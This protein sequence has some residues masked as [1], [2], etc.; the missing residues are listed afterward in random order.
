ME[1]PL[2]IDIVVIFGLSIGV[3][4]VGHRLRIP[5]IVGFLLTG[6]IAGPHSLGLVKAVHEVEMM[7]EIGVILLLFTIGIEFSLDKLLQIKRI[8]LVGGLVQVALTVLAS[9][10]VVRSFGQPL[11]HSVFVGFL[12][13]VSSTAI[14]LRLFQ[15]RAEIDSPHGR[16]AL[17]ILIFQDIIVVP[18]MLFTPFLAGQTTNLALELLVLLLKGA[19]IIAF[20]IVGSRWLVPPLLYQ[21]LRTRNRELFLLSI[22][23]LCFAVVLL[24]SGLGLSLALGAFLA[25]LIIS[26]SEYSHEALA[27]VLPFRNIFTGFFFVSVGMLLN[28]TFLIQH[29]GL[30]LLV[31]CG[32]LLLK[33]ILAVAATLVLGFSLRTAIMAGMALSQVGEFS[34][35]LSKIGV[36]HGLLSQPH[37]QLFLAVSV[38]TMATAPFIVSL[39][40]LVA[41]KTSTLPLPVRLRRNDMATRLS[42]AQPQQG[43]LVIVGFGLNG[44]NVARAAR[45]A[46]VPY[47]ILEMNAETVRQERKTGE[48]IHYGDATHESVLHHVRTEHAR[49]AVV[50]IND[51]SATRRITASIRENSPD[52]HLIVR[53]RYFGEVAAL[54]QLGADEVIPEEFEASLEVLMRVLTK[55]QIPPTEIERFTTELREDGYKEQTQ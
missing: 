45:A 8:S 18:M 53:T 27:N 16:V 19:G 35:V 4:L 55:Y 43:H 48:P 13:A 7:A 17:G 28:V 50:A 15:E 14:V 25:G 39:A 41:D 22:L 40:S 36:S 5:A 31:T 26:E 23:A 54:H 24:T 30:V 47:I 33:T 11:G 2:L 38:I 3:F 51:P 6:V 9:A 49:V 12:A 46:G 34:F 10:A 32:V 20:V 37:Y 52:I 42:F 21:I 44:R 29:L 1:I